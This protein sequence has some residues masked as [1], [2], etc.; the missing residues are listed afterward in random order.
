LRR[1]QRRLVIQYNFKMSVLF[2]MLGGAAEGY[3]SYEEQVA[4][5][6]DT[7]IA[8]EISG[9]DMLYSSG[10]TG[11][12]KGVMYTHRGAYLNALGNILAW[13]MQPHPVYLWTL[14]MS[15]P[16]R[17]PGRITVR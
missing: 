11:R 2:Q 9:S 15:L 12:P 10:T 17:K 6:P 16:S 1:K 4:L 14:P 13:N 8:D 7:P 5:Y 3:Q